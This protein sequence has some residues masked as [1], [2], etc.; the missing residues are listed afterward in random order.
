VKKRWKGG[1]GGAWLLPNPVSKLNRHSLKRI[2]IV[3]S[4]TS[5]MVPLV[6]MVNLRV[7]PK[8]GREYAVG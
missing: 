5:V 3:N 2:D 1:R 7:M 8:I 4:Q 6:L